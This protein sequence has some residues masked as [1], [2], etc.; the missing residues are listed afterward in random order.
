[1]N[2]GQ[3]ESDS[4]EESDPGPTR[5]PEELWSLDKL[6]FE[7]ISGKRFMMEMTADGSTV[8]CRGVTVLPKDPIKEALEKRLELLQIY[9]GY[10]NSM[11]G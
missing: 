10:C 9:C 5:N 11:Q 1:M 6:I 2:P 4:D 3:Y 8:L 7:T